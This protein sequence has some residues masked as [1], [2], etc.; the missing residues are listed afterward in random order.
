MELNPDLVAGTA[1]FVLL[2]ASWAAG[3]SSIPGRVDTLLAWA[4]REE[5][6]RARPRWNDEKK[7]T[8]CS[9]HELLRMWK[10]VLQ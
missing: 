6:Q 10:A 4:K 3:K 2:V 1:A 7:A 9:L 5:Y 8:V